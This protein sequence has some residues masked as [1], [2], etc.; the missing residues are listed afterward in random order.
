MIV[1]HSSALIAILLN[2]AEKVVFSEAI[3]AADNPQIA[4]HTFSKLRWW[5]RPDGA[6][7]RYGKGRHLAALNF[8]DCCAYALAKSLDWPLL[9]KG[10]DFAM[11]DLKRV[12]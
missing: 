1:V 7:R 5:Q 9:F 4:R 8:G 12:L 2:D 3:V 11:T 6:R 10:N